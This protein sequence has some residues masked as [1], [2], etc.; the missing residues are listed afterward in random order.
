MAKFNVKVLCKITLAFGMQNSKKKLENCL[1]T[2][3]NQINY[4]FL[5]HRNHMYLCNEG[6]NNE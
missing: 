2:G 1:E 5:L 6:E 3:G 4:R